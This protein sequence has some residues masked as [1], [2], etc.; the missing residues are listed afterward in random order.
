M[1]NKKEE[2]QDPIMDAIYKSQEEDKMLAKAFDNSYRVLTGQITF[3]TLLEQ[4]LETES[5]L[6]GFDPDAGP[7][8]EELENM[9]DWF[10]ET[11]EYEKCAK[12]NEILNKKYK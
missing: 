4:T 12:L 9:I 11:E 3:D 8:K 2:D 6:M 5:M 7:S 1:I 10:I